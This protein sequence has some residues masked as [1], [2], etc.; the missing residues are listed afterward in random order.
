MKVIGLTGGIASGKSTI[1]D[2][3]S[4]SGVP[5]LDADRWVHD[6]IVPGGAGEAAVKAAFPDAVANGMLERKLL[7]ALVFADDDKLKQL[8]AILHPLV[9][10]A[11]EDF[12]ASH[13][14]TGAKAVLLEIPL[15][16]ETGADALC[17]VT[18]AASAPETDRIARAMKRPNMTEAKLES[19]LAKQWTDEQR[20]ARATHVIHTGH[21]LDDTYAQVDALVAQWGI[22]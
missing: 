17:D 1:A 2:R 19:I 22:V 3:F 16:F 20:D 7:G 13:K 21:S 4:Q 6:A 12:I 11:E 10:K 15:L 18:I 14:A 8:E 9:R 5:V